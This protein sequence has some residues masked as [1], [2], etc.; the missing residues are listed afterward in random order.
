MSRPTAHP[1]VARI[2]ARAGFWIA[3]LATQGQELS[4]T[5]YVLPSGGGRTGNSRF[6][7][8]AT[9]G[10][11]VVQSTLTDSKDGPVSRA[12][13]WSQIVRWLNAPPSAQPDAVARRPGEGAHILVR[14][15][16]ANDRDPDFD[17]LA[18]VDFDPVTAL[19]GTVFREGPWLIYEPPPSAGPQAEDSFAYRMTDGSSPVAASVRIGPFIPSASGP[20]NSLSIVLDPSPPATV[21]VRFQGIAGRRYSVQ[22]A[23][24][25]SGPWTHRADVFAGAT[26]QVLFSEP[27]SEEPRFYRLVEPAP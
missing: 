6:T 19:G 15:L 25:P 4:V 8:D 3:C 7:L 2:A 24:A 18:F 5:P 14:Q 23:S 20:P 21:H 26:G 1:I 9:L 22:T 13:F 10:Q 17:S 16:L 27:P 11:S 12:G